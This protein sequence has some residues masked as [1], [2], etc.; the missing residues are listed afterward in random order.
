MNLL[1]RDIS[2]KKPTRLFFAMLLC[3][4]LAGC[5]AGGNEP[6][7]VV[8][9]PPPVHVED[10]AE[11]ASQGSL[12]SEG[13]ANLLFSDSRARNLG[14]IVFVKVQENTTARNKAT[15]KADRTNTGQYGV[16]AFFGH[17]KIGVN[18]MSGTVGAGPILEFSSVNSLD[19]DAETKRDSRVITVVASRVIGVLPGGVLQVEGSNETR[20][21]DETQHMV[22]T[23]LVRARDID[24]D[25][26][27][28]SSQMA[29]AR[30]ALFGKGTVS[31]KQ[32][33]GWLTRLMDT[34]WPF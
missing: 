16:T 29:N 6:G 5:M 8:T 2:M 33:P 31:D 17:D 11:A 9:T 34:I 7:P 28:L 14:D 10:Q 32:K 1:R 23:G 24:A 13:N 27:I 30:I 20:I 21:N 4:G 19:G 22:V 12:F 25:N 26:T 18:P 3:L 15:T